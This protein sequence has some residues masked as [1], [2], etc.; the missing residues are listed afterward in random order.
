MGRK[1]SEHKARSVAIVNVAVFVAVAA[2][3]IAVVVVDSLF[4]LVFLLE[5]ILLH[6]IAPKLFLFT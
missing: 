4:S 1:A 2:V 3:V 5:Y 6:C